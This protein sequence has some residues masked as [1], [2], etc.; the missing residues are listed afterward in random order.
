MN[1]SPY[2]GE[3]LIKAARA[4]AKAFL[5]TLDEATGYVPAKAAS[6]QDGATEPIEYDPLSDEPP[7]T[8][9][10]NGTGAQQQMAWITFLGAIARLNADE[11]RGARSDEISEFAKKAGYSGGNAV[12]G[13]N[14]RSNS[15]RNV[16]NLD[17][18]RF[19]NDAALGWITREAAKLGIKLVGEFATVPRPK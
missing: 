12:N 7:F 15:P 6:G 13:W 5:A 19:L 9:N 3:T 2:G 17:G 16:E 4:A 1:A 10:P 8:P 14:S 18:A 11:G